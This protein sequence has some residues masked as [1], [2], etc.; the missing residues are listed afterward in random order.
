M[1]LLSRSTPFLDGSCRN[2]VWYLCH[3]HHNPEHISLDCCSSRGFFYRANRNY[4]GAPV[5]STS[6][7]GRDPYPVVVLYISGG[8]T[9]TF[10]K[11]PRTYARGADKAYKFPRYP[12]AVS[13]QIP[14]KAERN[15]L[16]F[17]LVTARFSGSTRPQLSGAGRH[18]TFCLPLQR[19]YASTAA[20]CHRPRVAPRTR[21][22]RRSHAM[23]APFLG[24]CCVIALSTAPHGCT[25]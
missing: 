17:S 14:Q 15:R 3:E 6:S 2:V 18:S 20:L 22:T 23:Y 5:A 1:H 24:C 19:A 9:W 16:K 4:T 12:S 11:T 7:H 10:I 8:D 13:C 25:P 21:R